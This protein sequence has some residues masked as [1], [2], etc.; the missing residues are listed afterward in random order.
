M[1]GRIGRLADNDPWAG[2]ARHVAPPRAAAGLP[3]GLTKA[4]PSGRWGRAL[5]RHCR[6]AAGLSLG[7]GS[8]S[9]GPCPR[10]ARDRTPKR[11]RTRG[12]RGRR[13]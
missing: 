7:R 11:A 5:R 1:G 6:R 9:A 3:P 10:P 8:G 4:G 13:P 2:P 12:R